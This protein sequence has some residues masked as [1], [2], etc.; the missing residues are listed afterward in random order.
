MVKEED[1]IEFSIEQETHMPMMPAFYNVIR[2]ATNLANQYVTAN[3]NI[4]LAIKQ[5]ML[6]QCHYKL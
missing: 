6:L 4:N 1:T 5:K 2:T 3:N